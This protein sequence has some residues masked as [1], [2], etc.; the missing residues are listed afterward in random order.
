MRMARL[1]DLVRVGERQLLGEVIRVDRDTAVIQ[2]FEET[3]GLRLGEPVVGTGS[4]LAV[5][6]GPG[7]LGSVF[8]GV[9][10]PLER[11]A[12]AGGNTIQPGVTAPT[13]DPDRQ[14]DFT[15]RRTVGETIRGGDVLGTVEERT[16]FEHRV[17]V[18]P[19]IQEGIL[20]E[21]HSGAHTIN[22]VVALVEDGTPLRMAQHWPVRTPRPIRGRKPGDRPFVTGQRVFDLFFP[23]AEGGAV[24]VPGGFGTGKTVIE[25]SLAK[26]ADADVVVYVGCGERGNEMAEVLS[27]FPTLVDPRSGIPV[28]D[29]TVLIVNTSNMPVAAR[30]SSV[31]MGLTIAEYYRDM[32]YRVAVMADSLSRWAEAL[33]EIG[34]RLQEMPGEEGYPTSLP[35]RL[36]KVYERAGRVTSLGTPEREGAVTFIS[37]VSPGGGDFSEPVTQASLRVAGALW[38]LDPDLAHQ[39][40]FPAVDW[41]IS[42]SLYAEGLAAW[43]TEHVG[44]K[45]HELRHDLLEMLQRDREIREIAALVGAEALEDRDRLV[46]SVARLIRDT[47]LG[48]SAFDP[49]DA[50]SSLEKTLDLGRLAREAHTRASLALEDGTA[51]EQLDFSV[52]QQALLEVRNAGVE[53]A[54]AVERAE[55]ALDTLR[56]VES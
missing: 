54:A 15:P 21:I 2:V 32:G 40:H 43:F 22:D 23:V 13:L 49:N 12:T 51:F 41:E 42:Y 34:G 3:S 36:G 17:L 20:T 1:Y 8:D 38:A 50:H 4:A 16:G 14:W 25:Q 9:G 30:E 18:P 48:Q 29:R 37:A 35:N 44:Q 46:L 27:E 6:L 28:M 5:E 45:W 31:Y 39:R 53:L 52:V 47:V 33:R 56:M 26:F 55:R 11:L 10:R 19:V 7:L 24:A